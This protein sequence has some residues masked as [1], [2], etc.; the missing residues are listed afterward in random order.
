MVI[1]L[2]KLINIFRLFL[3]LAIGLIVGL[4]I[5]NSIDYTTLIK[6]PL[7]PPSITFPIVWSILYL[8]M[9]I[10]Y[11]LYRKDNNNPHTIRNYYYQL[12]FNYLWSILFFILKLRFLSIICILILDALVIYLYNSFLSQSKKSSY[13]LMPYIIWILFATYLNI[14]IYILN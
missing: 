11:Y 6:P 3:P 4:L 14:G 12:L 8:L 13:L 9:G 5:N 1:N 7:S 2:N 10:S